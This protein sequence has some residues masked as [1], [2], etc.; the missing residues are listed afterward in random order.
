MTVST[1]TTRESGPALATRALSCI[2]TR[3]CPVGW[4]THLIRC[5][6]G[7]FHAPPGNDVG[8][9]GGE[10]VFL[11]LFSANEVIGIAAGVMRACRLTDKP[12]HFYFP[13][14]P[15]LAAGIRPGLALDVLLAS[16]RSIDAAELVMESF[17]AHWSA[18]AATEP[19]DARM[20]EEYV[21]PLTADPALMAAGLGS[22]H[23]RQIRKA[24]RNGW[25]IEHPEGDEARAILTSVQKVAA[26]RAA[27]RGHG[28]HVRVPKLD[29]LES[30]GLRPWG[31]TMFVAS[32]DGAPLAAALV[33]WANRRAFYVMGGSTAAGY[34]CGASL[35]LHWRIACMLGAAG[36]A[37]YNL[38]GA[39]P[40]A[41]KPGHPSHGLYRFKVGFGAR[42][43]PCRS[44]SWVLSTAHQ[45]VH[46]LGR[47][48]GQTTSSFAQE[49]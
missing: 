21:V 5:D 16:L 17:D 14:L 48:L 1:G 26:R 9:P 13:T 47:W 36:F 32:Q 31:A 42:A 12:R 8:G 49:T 11:R 30:A 15:A 6:G 20:R 39:T 46:Q 28:F 23:R 34:E 33:G 24:E 45:R 37:T 4:D 41:A 40:E 29:A 25:R 22:G 35:W 27:A 2:V 18:D 7:F 44:M 38:G 3:E 43:V 19:T 10:P